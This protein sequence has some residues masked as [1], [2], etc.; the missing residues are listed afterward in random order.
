MHHSHTVRFLFLT[1]AFSGSGARN[2]S[3]VRYR[4]GVS[5]IFSYSEKHSDVARLLQIL[6]KVETLLFISGESSSGVDEKLS[7][8]YPETVVGEISGSMK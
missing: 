7:G 2:I 6:N 1:A 8:V 4:V 5:I 3:E